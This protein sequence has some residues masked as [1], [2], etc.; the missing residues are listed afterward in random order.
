MSDKSIYD[1]IPYI[2]KAAILLLTVGEEAAA[3]ILK[4]LGPR[5]AKNRNFNGNFVRCKA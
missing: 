5:S 1:A 3:N 4:Q 2:E